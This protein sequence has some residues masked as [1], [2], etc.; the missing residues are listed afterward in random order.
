MISF[1]F[2]SIKYFSRFVAFENIF[3]TIVMN[4]YVL[5]TIIKILS[6]SLFSFLFDQ[7]PLNN[8]GNMALF[9]WEQTICEQSYE[10]L[11]VK[12]MY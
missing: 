2:F 8:K 9:K 3:K 7:S 5:H 12:N 11:T 1:I 4:L 6:G 10:K